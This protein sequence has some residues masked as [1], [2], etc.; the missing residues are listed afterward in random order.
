MQDLEPPPQ[1]GG[2]LSE[3][4]LD[5]M[6]RLSSLEFGPAEAGLRL[7]VLSAGFRTEA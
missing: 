3:F 7:D 6:A 1:A 2:F 4:L 5:I